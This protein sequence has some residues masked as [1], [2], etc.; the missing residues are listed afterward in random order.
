MKTIDELATECF[1]WAE[2]VF[3]E[4]TDSSMGLKLYSE[5]G[6]MMD[7]DGDPLEVADVL[8]MVLDYAKRK[9]I[10]IESAV[11]E[12]LDINRTRTW[13]HLHNGTMR[14]VE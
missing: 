6:E 3:P 9:G 7:S 14:H 8:I 2:S 1:D 5:V 10:D 4:R 11:T 12:K 13:V